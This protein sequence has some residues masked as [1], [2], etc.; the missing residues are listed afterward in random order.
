ML[1]RAEPG[2]PQGA[3][4]SGHRIVHPARQTQDPGEG[5]GRLDQLR[6]LPGGRG[7]MLPH[8][9]DEAGREAP[10]TEELRPDEGVRRPG[11]P[12]LGRPHRGVVL[13]R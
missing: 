5:I 6:H 4:G 7:V 1:P 3:P 2:R 8:G 9:G 12:L 11:E 10:V 13:T